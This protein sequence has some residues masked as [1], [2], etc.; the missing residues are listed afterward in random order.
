MTGAIFRL[1]GVI[2]G[3]L[4]TGAVEALVGNG[5]ATSGLWSSGRRTAAER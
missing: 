5:A 4:L 2:I 1:V 3:G